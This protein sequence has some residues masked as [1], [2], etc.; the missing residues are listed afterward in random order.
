[1]FEMVADRG[2][3]CSLGQGL[4]GC[5]QC[6]SSVQCRI[7]RSLLVQLHIEWVSLGIVLFVLHGSGAGSCSRRVV[8]FKTLSEE[9]KISAREKRGRETIAESLSVKNS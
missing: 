8:G 7:K 6:D 4:K 5:S 2:L 3:R 9:E 1:M